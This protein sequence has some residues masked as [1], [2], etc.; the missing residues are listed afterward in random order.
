MSSKFTKI[1]IITLVTA[2]AAGCSYLPSTDSVLPDRKTEYKKSR[3]A[4]RNLEIPPD[5]TRSS[6]SD[7]LVIPDTPA[8]GVNT[9]SGF[10]SREGVRG[11]VHTRTAVLPQL[12]NIEVRR[13]GDKRWLVIKADAEDVWYKVVEF[14]QDNGIILI[15][16][17]PLVGTMLTDWLEN[18]AVI[19]TDAVTDTVRRLFDALYDAGTR[20]Q[21]RVR[22]ER[23]IEPDTTELYLTHR[24]MVEE[25]VVNPGGGGDT[26]SLIWKPSESDPGLEAEML[27]RIM[28]YLGVS[29]QRAR[30]A[31]AGS[32]KPAIPLSTLQRSRDEVSLEISEGFDRAWRITGVALDRV[33]FAVEDRD[34]KEGTYYVRYS[35][36]MA[37]QEEKGFLA[38]L[39]FWRN[40]DEFSVDKQYQVRL[41]QG[42]EKTQIRIFDQAGNRDNSETALR[43]LTLLKEQIK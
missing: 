20:D 23:G 9:L 41:S 24:G 34:R 30:G 12:E 5:L 10:E 4:E 11:R 32:G 18:R 14:W 21:Y 35:D 16:Q 7:E 38:K 6:I 29:E 43:I 40:D 19:K 27:N 39:A 1:A 13:D 2:T 36:P 28:V 17:D 25:A 26:E 33:G 15:E 8:S 31:L 37:G 3:Q 42:G 22:I